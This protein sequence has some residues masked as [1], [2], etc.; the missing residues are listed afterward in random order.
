MQKVE[1]ELKVLEEQHIIEKVNGSTPW[2]SPLVL[3]PKKSGAVRVCVDMCRANKAITC[4]CHPTPT[5]DDLIQT[6]NGATVF[7]KL[8]LRSGYHQITLAPQFRYI[9]MFA[10][11]H[12]LW[13]YCRLNFGMNSA[14]EIFLK[15]INQQICDIPG[16]LNISDDVIIFGKIQD[17]HDNALKAV[18]QK[19]A[20]VNLTL[21]KSKC[22]FNKQSI[23]FFGF[24]FSEKSI[25][26]DPM[27]VE[28]IEK[29][30]P[31]TTTDAV[32]S[33]LGMATYCTKFIPHFSDVSEPL[34]KLTKKDEPF[35]WG[36]EQETSFHT[37][38]NLLTSTDVMAYFDPNKETELV[39]D[40]SP[41]GLSAIL[42][43]NTPGIKD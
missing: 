37:I 8:D 24:V 19:F 18:F 38:K 41:L 30:F 12:G 22:E 27:K 35:L 25:S 1:H 2:V 10:T 17:D 26:P 34:C 29:A 14:S 32:R 42:M 21:N 31:A 16:A 3:I 9:A 20:E 33:F 23:S 6:L 4:E 39:T 7:S 40:A 28:S 36:K 15:L 5:I 13:R 11:H 43:Q